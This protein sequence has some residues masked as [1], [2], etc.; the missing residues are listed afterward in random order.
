MALSPVRSSGTWQ[1]IDVAGI[2]AELA[3]EQLEDVR[4]HRLLDLEPDG[5]TEAPAHE[6]AFEGLQQVLGLVLVDVEV[7]VAGHPEGV[8]LQ[9]LHAGKQL[10]EMGGDDVLERH[11][12]F[13]AHVREA[14]QQRRHLDP[15]EVLLPRLRVAH[16]D[17]QD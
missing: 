12:V 16:H 3:G 5:R 1:R 11:E 14:R 10:L 6:L 13:V 8:V 4:V 9:H 2:D 7:L 17:R 15:R